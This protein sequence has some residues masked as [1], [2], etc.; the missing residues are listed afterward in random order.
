MWLFTENGFVSAIRYNNNKDE[1]TVRA[2]DKK[3]LRSIVDFTG[4]KII[5]KTDTDYPYRVI[6]EDSEWSSW[7]AE[8]A[9]KIDY[10]NFKN[11]V[12]QTRGKSFAHLLSDVWGIMLGAE[13]IELEEETGRPISDSDFYH[14]RRF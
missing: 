6:I 14:N 12:Y 2:R 8:Q 10:P 11:R 7:V 3:S 9:L 13:K 5:K 1:I 4:A